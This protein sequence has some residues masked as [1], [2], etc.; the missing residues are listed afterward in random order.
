MKTYTCKRSPNFNSVPKI[1]VATFDGNVLGRNLFWEQFE[2]SIQSKIHISDAE[3]LA[4]LRQAVKDGPAKYVIEGLAHLDTNYVNAV[5]CLHKRY[6]K[7]RQIHKAHIKAILDA[8]S[9]RNE[10]GKKLRRLH[11]VLGKHLPAL[12]AMNNSS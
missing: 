9:I 7:P 4:Y 10:T 12:E 3:K 5:E 11:D 6:D 2:V 1:E 8:A